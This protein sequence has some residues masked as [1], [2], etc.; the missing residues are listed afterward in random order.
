MKSHFFSNAIRLFSRQTLT[1]AFPLKCSGL[2]CRE[3][4]FRCFINHGGS[5]E[6]RTCYESEEAERR[7]AIQSEDRS[8]NHS[9]LQHVLRELG[10]KRC[11]II[12]KH[13]YNFQTRINGYRGRECDCSFLTLLFSESSL[14]RCDLG[15][16]CHLRLASWFLGMWQTVSPAIAEGH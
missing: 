7:V 8:L 4:H 1:S 15:R 14:N 13:R 12:L 9:V 10:S 11:C 5:G 6:D 2:R 3:T 16:G